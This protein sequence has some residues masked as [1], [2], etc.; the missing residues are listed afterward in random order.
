MV[1]ADMDSSGFFFPYLL[2]ARAGSHVV[3]FV[4]FVVFMVVVVVVVLV[5]VVV[6]TWTSSPSELRRQQHGEMHR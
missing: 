6:V 1:C 3:V 5:V 2:R 4:V